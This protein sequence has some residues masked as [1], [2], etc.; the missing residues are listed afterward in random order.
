MARHA[1]LV[2]AASDI[3]MSMMTRCLVAILILAPSLPGQTLKQVATIDL[4]VPE[5]NASTM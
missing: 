3:L 4:P 1:N 2:A 5:A